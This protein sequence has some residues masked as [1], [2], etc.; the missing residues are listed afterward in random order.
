M[1]A[2][3]AVFCLGNVADEIMMDQINSE[4]LRASARQQRNFGGIH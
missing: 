4:P 3:A 2:S 1:V